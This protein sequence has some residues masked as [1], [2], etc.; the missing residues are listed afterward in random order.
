MDW[1][2]YIILGSI[3]TIGLVKICK[4]FNKRL[5][6]YLGQNL[7]VSLKPAPIKKPTQ[8]VG[9]KKQKQLKP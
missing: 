8:S 1:L 9:T 4:D 6:E 5:F 7:S 3:L 2:G